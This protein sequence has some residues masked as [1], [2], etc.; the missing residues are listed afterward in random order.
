MGGTAN[1]R[2][3]TFR[4]VRRSKYRT[5]LAGSFTEAKLDANQEIFDLVADQLS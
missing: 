5:T 2:S 4:A 3:T 1:G